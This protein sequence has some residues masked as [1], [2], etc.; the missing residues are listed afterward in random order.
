MATQHCGAAVV[1]QMGYLR[2]SELSFLRI[3][4]KINVGGV[5][6]QQTGPGDCWKR[7]VGVRML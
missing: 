2:I 6:W 7:F 5:D 4:H 3:F 1:T